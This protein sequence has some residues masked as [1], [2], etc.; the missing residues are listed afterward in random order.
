MYYIK[1]NGKI[2]PQTFELISQA[3]AEIERLRG[4]VEVLSWNILTSDSAASEMGSLHGKWHF[5]AVEICIAVI[6]MLLIVSGALALWLRRPATIS[7]TYYVGPQLVNYRNAQG[8]ILGQL[9]QGTSVS[10]RQIIDNRCQALINGHNV[11][12]HTNV[13]QKTKK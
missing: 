2:Q 13:L 10:C 12:I 11:Y 8:T 9:K 5:S 3:R 6:L 1:I 4:E 7:A